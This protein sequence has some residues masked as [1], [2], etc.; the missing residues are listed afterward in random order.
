MYTNRDSIDKMID[1]NFSV[2]DD[3]RGIEP[4]IDFPISISI[5]AGISRG[6]YRLRSL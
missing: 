6:M 2:L 5:G 1:D 4:S 3:V